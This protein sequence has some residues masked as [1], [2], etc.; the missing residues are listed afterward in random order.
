MLALL[1]VTYGT[2]DSPANL[3]E[4]LLAG[5]IPSARVPR[6]RFRPEAGGVAAGAQLLEAGKPVQHLAKEVRKRL[7]DRLV[8]VHRGR[9]R[10][11]RPP[12]P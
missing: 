6:D 8:R 2:L 1:E 7:G 3:L 12:G 9:M 11:G 10:H 4:P 5:W